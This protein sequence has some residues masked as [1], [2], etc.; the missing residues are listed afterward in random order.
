MYCLLITYTIT[1]SETYEEDKIDYKYDVF[2]YKYKINCIS[3]Y[4]KYK[5]E[6]E[7][8][9]NYRYNN[10]SDSIE[11]IEYEIYDIEFED[12]NEEASR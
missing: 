5:L 6:L 8:K 2:F 11:D 4:N 10:I 9:Y 1:I 12:E 3:K 7:N